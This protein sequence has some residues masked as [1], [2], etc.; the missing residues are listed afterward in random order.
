MS[1]NSLAPLPQPH[2]AC[3][4]MARLPTVQEGLS[5][6]SLTAVCTHHATLVA[7]HELHDLAGFFLP[8]EH[9]ATV[10]A[11][12]HKFTLGAVEVDAFH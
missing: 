4:H 7:L 1:H 8:Q 5:R 10:A 3:S 9:V 11:A 6:L 2:Q 12:D